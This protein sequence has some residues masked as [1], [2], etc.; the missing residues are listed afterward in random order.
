VCVPEHG[1]TRGRDKLTRAVRINFSAIGERQSFVS[2]GC[3]L[4]KCASSAP[5]ADGGALSGRVKGAS[6]R[7]AMQRSCTL[8]SAARRAKML[9]TGQSIGMGFEAVRSTV[10]ANFPESPGVAG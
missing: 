4:V 3:W 2:I 5:I 9:R 1:G 7:N 8:D 10:R 6:R